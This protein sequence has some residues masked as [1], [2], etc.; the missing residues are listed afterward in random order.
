MDRVRLRTAG[1]EPTHL[2]LTRYKRLRPVLLA[3]KMEF[4]TSNTLDGA[5]AWLAAN[6]GPRRLT[7]G[8]DYK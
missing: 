8:P 5:R 4:K 6:S 7:K 3:Q 2:E 1:S